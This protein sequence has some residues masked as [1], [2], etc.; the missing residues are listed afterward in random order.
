M[1]ELDDLKTEVAVLKERV[2]GWM[3]STTEYRQVLCKKIDSIKEVLA[4]LSC[5]VHLAKIDGVYAQLKFMW[6]IIGV[7]LIV[8]VTEWLKGR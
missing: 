5:P 4:S 8:I 3:G 1:S 2:E 7:M 6:S